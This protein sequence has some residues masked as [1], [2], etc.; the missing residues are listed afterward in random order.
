MIISE[1]VQKKFYDNVRKTDSCWIYLKSIEGCSY[2]RMCVNGKTVGA[3]R[4]SYLIHK[5]SIPDKMFV[6]HKCDNPSCVN[7]EHLFL[8]SPKDNTEDMTISEKHEKIVLEFSEH[9]ELSNSLKLLHYGSL[10]M[11]A[12]NRLDCNLNE[13]LNAINEAA[14]QQI[15]EHNFGRTIL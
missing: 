9:G 12:M 7:P 1:A 4:V 6:C 15:S 10:L 2:G 14:Q 13:L 5:G 8:G 3:H 11:T